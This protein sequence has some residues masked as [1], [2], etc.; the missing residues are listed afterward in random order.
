[1]G[2]EHKRNTKQTMPESNGVLLSHDDIM[3]WLGK[4]GASIESFNTSEKLKEYIV[5]TINGATDMAILEI[6]GYSTKTIETINKHL[7][8]SNFFMKRKRVSNDSI[9]RG[10]GVFVQFSLEQGIY[11]DNFLLASPIKFVNDKKVEA[12]VYS[13]H[14]TIRVEDKEVQRYYKFTIEDGVIVRRDFVAGKR[15][16]FVI[17]PKQEITKYPTE[18]DELPIALLPYNEKYK[19]AFEGL[20]DF[21]SQPDKYLAE[22]DEEWKYDQV[23]YQMNELVDT[24]LA[25]DEVQKKMDGTTTTKD[26]KKVR[27]IS[28]D[29]PNQ[30][31]QG[32]PI[33]LL[34]AGGVSSQVAIRNHDFFKRE[35]IFY[36][37]FWL[38]VSDGKTN[39]HGAETLTTQLTFFNKITFQKEMR[40]QFYSEFIYVYAKLLRSQNLITEDIKEHPE[41]SVAL[42]PVIQ[43]IMDSISN[44]NTNPITKSGKTPAPKKG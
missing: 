2:K 23:M 10:V 12:M 40:E 20:E 24:S 39:K 3:E 13:P 28:Y 25:A 8:K 27:I 44:P 43:V 32:G 4:S 35:V 21:I 15:K 18:L 34:S 6:K 14:D 37:L 7:K 22:V 1:M 26:G 30:T 38:M 41:V 36:T 33:G 19:G 31:G 16:D 42:S 11:F 9:Q 17:P 29:D 5:E